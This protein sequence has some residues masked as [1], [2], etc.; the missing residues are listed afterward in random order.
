MT[1]TY[2]SSTS[3]SVDKSKAEIERLLRRYGADSFASGWDENKAMIGFAM[4]GRQI[5]FTLPMPD[6]HERAFTLTETG[7]ARS[8]AAAEAAYEQA[9]RSRWRAL[10]LVIK[11]KLEAVQSGIVSFEDEW[12]THVVL[13]D[14]ST[15][16]DRLFPYIDS[17]YA[18]GTVPPMLAL[19][20][21]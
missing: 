16:R 8:P 12:A 15:V 6:S 3:V 13:P 4:R 2:A 1:T 5:R 18:T 21:T 14:G 19:G 20:S 17:A 10:A 11:A 7:R 9:I